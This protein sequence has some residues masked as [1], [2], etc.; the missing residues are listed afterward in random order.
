MAEGDQLHI[1]YAHVFRV[2]QDANR[3]ANMFSRNAILNALKEESYFISDTKKIQMGLNGTR[4]MV[5]TLD[6]TKAPD[7]IKN[8]ALGNHQ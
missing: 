5:V 6:L 1:W 3:G 7:S 8:I 2:V 4:R